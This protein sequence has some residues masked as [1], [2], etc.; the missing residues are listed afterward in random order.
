MKE[1]S[2]R[3]VTASWLA[4]LAVGTIAACLAL[5]GPVAW[6][7]ETWLS[8]LGAVPASRPD[9]AAAAAEEAEGSA[10]PY[11]VTLAVEYALVSDYIWRGAN[12]SEAPRERTEKLNHQL[13][14][15]LSADLKDL[16]L[17]DF[18]SITFDVWFEWYEGQ[19]AFGPGVETTLQ[20]VDYTL[21]W[22]YEVPETP[23]TVELGWIAYTFPNATGDFYS[24]YEVYGSISLNDGA[25]FGSEDGVLN[26]SVT[27][28]WDYDVVKAGSLVVG[29]EHEFDLSA[30]GDAP[31]LRATT[32]TPSLGL[33]VDNRYWDKALAP[34]GHKST[35]LAT[36]EVGLKAGFDLNELLDIPARYGGF[37]AGVFVNF[38]DAL[39]EDLLNDE[40]YGGATVGFEW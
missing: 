15:S 37:S 3:N 39:R 11:P 34:T 18:G 30:L 13:D 12:F 21:S 20:E 33:L 1:P 4:R 17:P 8:A 23:V 7:Q 27:Y 6:A 22:S 19:R 26:P 25:L 9:N 35:R 14:V 28:Y 32:I 40:F 10:N 38:S 2:S 5:T 24:S 29:F 16:N 31:L 36:V